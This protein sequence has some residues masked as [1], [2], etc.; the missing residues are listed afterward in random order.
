VRNDLTS[1]FELVPGDI[2]VESFLSVQ[3]ILFQQSY[4]SLGGFLIALCFSLPMGEP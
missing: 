2:V 3:Y 4:S 1:G